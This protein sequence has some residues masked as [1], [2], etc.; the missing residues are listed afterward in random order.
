M[1][2]ICNTCVGGRIYEYYK[3]QY[4][5]PFIWNAINTPDFMLLVENYDNINFNNFELVYKDDIYQM[6][7][8][9]LIIVTYPH[10]KYDENIVTPIIKSDKFG[11]HMYSNS[12]DK[13]IIDRYVERL[14]RMNEAPTFILIKGTTFG[15]NI[16]C[17][18]NDIEYFI[19]ISS[20]YSKIVYT[21]KIYDSNIINNTQIINGKYNIN[22]VDIAK[23]I[24]NTV[25]L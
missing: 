9:N 18:D 2:I 15:K 22:S 8:D 23:T 6:N 16:K 5:N 20:K 19:N 24:I 4:T 11:T 10:Y 12:I 21:D 25:K 1:N 3:L 17:L 13:Y 14:K 7:I